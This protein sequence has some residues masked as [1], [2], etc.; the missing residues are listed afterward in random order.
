[1][2]ALSHI[3]MCRCILKS[4]CTC[5][6][7]FIFRFTFVFWLL[8][9]FL[10]IPTFI[11]LSHSSIFVCVYFY[12]HLYLWIFSSISVSIFTLILRSTCIWMVLC[13]GVFIF[14]LCALYAFPFIRAYARAF[15]THT[16]Y[17]HVRMSIYG[18]VCCRCLQVCRCIFNAK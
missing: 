3:Y 18:H 5:R 1:M 11:G 8:F 15:K 9:T 6:L 10:F 17:L 13:M 16:C 2:L 14:Y 7:R 12:L 4:I